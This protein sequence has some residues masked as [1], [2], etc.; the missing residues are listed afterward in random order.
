MRRSR[1]AGLVLSAFV[2]VPLAGCQ[3]SPQ[4]AS[5]ASVQ[6]AS[7]VLADAAARTSRVDV[8]LAARAGG[9]GVSG[10]YSA[11]TK[12]GTYTNLLNA[13]NV[14]YTTPTTMLI[15]GVTGIP[16]NSFAR[17]DISQMR[18]GCRF[19][20]GADPVFA[21]AML[22][23]GITGAGQTGS[24]TYSGTVDLARITGSAATKKTAE[25]FTNVVSGQ[26]GAIRFTATLDQTG[27]VSAVHA[28][29]G[30]LA[31]DLN[32]SDFSTPTNVKLP[33][34][35]IVEAPPHLYG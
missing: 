14:F 23:G 16:D 27:Y 26:A 11:G 5:V 32:L 33:T 17:L 3:S 25:F 13:R 18:A 21:L 2:I 20:A 15:S 1:I 28:D 10:A 24:L 22:S 19:A 30:A 29:F 31:Y 4:V 35:G 8:R 9:D 6:T 34:S 12:T 7:Q